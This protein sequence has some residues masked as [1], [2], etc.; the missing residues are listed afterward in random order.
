MNLVML[1]TQEIVIII[2]LVAALLIFLSIFLPLFLIRSKYENFVL[3]HS[4][5]LQQLNEINKKYRFRFVKPLVLTHNYDNED[6]YDIVSCTDYLLYYLVDNQS[7]VNRLISDTLYNKNLNEQYLKEIKNTCLMDVYDVSDL[8][9]NR[10]RLQKYEERMFLKTCHY[11]VT[12]TEVVVELR[13][14]NYYGNFV[15]H[16]KSKSYQ[17]KL[18]KEFIASV[19]ARNGRYFQI[20]DVWD[21]IC[22]VERAKVSNKMRFAIYE[23]DHNRCVKCGSRHNLEIDHIIPIAKGGKSTFDN[24]QTLCHRCNKAKGTTIEKYTF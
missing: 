19:N 18:L 6:Y 10:K 24:L 8:P 16:T 14:T 21:A 20:R 15:R 4:V 17:P 9:K 1:D 22:R 5:A 13:L 23:R 7:R 11:P 12:E 2:I 3:V